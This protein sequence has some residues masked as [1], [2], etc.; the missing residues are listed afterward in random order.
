MYQER[1]L[2]Q[3]FLRQLC[4]FKHDLYMIKACAFQFANI[5]SSQ[6]VHL[7]QTLKTLQEW[8]NDKS[9]T[10]VD[11][12]LLV[13]LVLVLAEHKQKEGQQLL[14]AFLHKNTVYTNKFINISPA[15]NH[16]YLSEDS[17]HSICQHLKQLGFQTHDINYIDFI[18][19][20]ALPIRFQGPFLLGS[21]IKDTYFDYMA[22]LLY[23][24]E[25]EQEGMQVGEHMKILVSLLDSKLQLLQN[26]LSHLMARVQ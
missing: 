26:I 21:N 18:L 11:F 10:N 22:Y 13:R 8:L 19:F 12:T 4:H 14:V 20:K 24:L 23:S 9:K 6:G 17:T 3:G 15:I 2:V 25:R 16:F 5:L 1:Q 7:K